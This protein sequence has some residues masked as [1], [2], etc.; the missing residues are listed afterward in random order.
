ML[1]DRVPPLSP[2]FGEGR[3][4]FATDVENSSAEYGDA[5]S[6]SNQ[7]GPTLCVFV[8]ILYADGRTLWECW[9]CA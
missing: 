8:Y 2:S 5:A 6:Q 1:S 4:F 3:C 7:Y 9:E